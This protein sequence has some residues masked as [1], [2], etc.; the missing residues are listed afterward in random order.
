MRRF[1]MKTRIAIIFSLCILAGIALADF[2]PLEGVTL[3]EMLGGE[4]IKRI[5]TTSSAIEVFRLSESHQQTQPVKF[6]TSNTPAV[7][8]ALT[9]V[10]NYGGRYLCDFDPGV[11]F[12]FATADGTLDII[13]CFTC[14][15]MR[16]YLDGSVVKRNIQWVGSQNSFSP[17]ARRAFVSLAKKAFPK[18][19]QI[20]SLHQ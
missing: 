19:K 10:K 13:I 12:R 16:L 11:K 17:V 14:G 2:K 20:Q 18:D 15:E 5:I 6:A 4:K 9:E 3:E 1:Q 8:A 7:I